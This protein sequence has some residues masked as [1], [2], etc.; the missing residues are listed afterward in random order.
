MNDICVTE[1]EHYAT[2]VE[3]LQQLCVYII[4]EIHVNTVHCEMTRRLQTDGRIDMAAILVTCRETIKR[5][6]PLIQASVYEF[7]KAVNEMSNLITQL[8]HQQDM[9]LRDLFRAIYKSYN[10][11]IRM[12]GWWVDSGVFRVWCGQN[13]KM[14]GQLKMICRTLKKE[15]RGIIKGV[16][17]IVYI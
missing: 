6:Y 13:E 7:D 17:D 16:G 12:G 1:T 9:P 11:F 14:Y 10:N 15:P 2:D 5:K 8:D 4:N 3:H